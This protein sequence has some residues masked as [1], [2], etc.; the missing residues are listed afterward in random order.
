MARNPYFD[1]STTMGTANERDLLRSL[2]TESIQIFGI[3]TFYMPRKLID[4]DT[5]FNED[6]F[7]EYNNAFPIE[8]YV[9]N[10]TAFEGDRAFMGK[11]GIQIQDQLTISVSEESWSNLVKDNDQLLT[12]RPAESDLIYIPMV[13]GFFEIKYV[14]PFVPFFQLGGLYTFR[15][16]CE[17]MTYSHQTINTGFSDVDSEKPQAYDPDWSDLEF[18][19]NDP[20]ANNK[21]LQDLADNILDFDETANPFGT[22]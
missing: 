13:K 18:D 1:G 12:A 10:F 4:L 2:T 15:M 22:P 6:R 17:R 14:D 9:E 20:F 11:F 16:T 7:S 19:Q 8:M 5:L 3:D 21:E